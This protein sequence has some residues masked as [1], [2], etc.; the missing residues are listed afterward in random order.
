MSR[1]APAAPPMAP[2][3]PPGE[4]MR[5]ARMGAAFPTRLSF[6]RALVREMAA[7]G[8]R[9]SRPLWQ[10]DEKGHG[11]AVYVADLGGQK[12]SLV[13]FSQPLADEARTDR[14]IAEA[15]DTTYALFDGVPGPEDIERLA[16]NV[17]RQEAGRYSARELVLCRANRSVRLFEHVAD[18]LAAGRQPEMAEVARVGYLMRTTA[19]YGNGK[20]GIA[21]R[22]LIARRPIL[23]G[24]FRAELLTVWLI[25]GFTLDLVEHVAAARGG[26]GAARLDPAIRRFLGIGNATGLGMAPFMASH[27]VLIHNWVLARETALARVRALERADARSIERFRALLARARRHVAEW[28]TDDA[29]QMARIETLREELARLERLATA[30]WLAAPRPWE[31][32]IAATAPLSLEAQEMAV[33]LVIE[34]HGAL[35]DDLAAQMADNEGARLD[36][37]MPLARL[38]DILR[39][40]YGWAL[41]IDF[42][43][44]ER[45]R[46]FWYTSEEKLEPRLGDRFAEPGAEKE[47]PLDIAL[48]VQ[49]LARAL[50]EADPAA[51]VAELLL[52]RPD[53]RHIVRRVQTVARHPYAEIRDNLIDARCLPIDLLRFKLAFFG[54]VKFDPRS[55]RWTRITMYQGAP[56]FDEVL[57]PDADDWSFPV[58]PVVEGG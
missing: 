19:V 18:R 40:H 8:V 17:P 25:R 42:A 24:P 39:E 4:V 20:F 28:T 46:L 58:A 38:A 43:D 37:A 45:R 44:P 52:G 30:E 33:A 32:V 5:L 13:A 53:L 31:R 49:A 14:V 34:P 36:P 15:W 11:R 26:A 57:A 47:M 16:A 2:L 22:A 55:D 7:A 35:V 41:A 48:Q 51:P 21:D 3:R 10:I 1:A 27:P 23:A 54:A 50:D 6:M 12:L 29:R 56:G 9:V